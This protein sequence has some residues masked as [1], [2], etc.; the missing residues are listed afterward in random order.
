MLFMNGEGKEKGRRGKEEWEEG[1]RRRRGKSKEG[2]W[3]RGRREGA[4]EAKARVEER[5]RVSRGVGKG[6]KIV[7]RELS[8]MQE[9]M[10]H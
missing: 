4:G 1:G 8:C 10:R 5:R 2:R 3:R 7:F 9:C 6:R